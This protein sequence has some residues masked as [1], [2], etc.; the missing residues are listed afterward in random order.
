MSE[1]PNES[2]TA[3]TASGAAGPD[4]TG[5]SRS[6]A[7]TVTVIAVSLKPM[8]PQRVEL[9]WLGTR[10]RVIPI[11]DKDPGLVIDLLPVGGGR[12]IPPDL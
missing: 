8:L 11:E 2:I 12:F 6:A 5:L 10:S 1:A 3:S 4:V 7:P 9:L